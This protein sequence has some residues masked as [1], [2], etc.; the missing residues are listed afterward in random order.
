MNNELE[1]IKVLKNEIETLNNEKERTK[2]E[3]E[4]CLL[5]IENT[6]DEMKPITEKYNNNF[7]K[8]NY[9]SKMK[10]SKCLLPLTIS[11]FLLMSHSFIQVSLIEMGKVESYFWGIFAGGGIAII[12]NHSFVCVFDIRYNYDNK[13]IQYISSKI[14]KRIFKKYPYLEETYNELI[15]LNEELSEKRKKLE[16]LENDKIVLKDKIRSI[17]ILINTKK[18]ELIE[19]N[20]KVFN[21]LVEENVLVKEEEIDTTNVEKRGKVRVRV[22]KDN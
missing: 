5:N 11:I 8:F 19:L 22:P 18:D 12:Y 3:Y 1:Q 13:F 2:S 9:E 10:I 16:Q 17:E 6:S 7:D 20:D 15:S 14:R 21:N 4:D